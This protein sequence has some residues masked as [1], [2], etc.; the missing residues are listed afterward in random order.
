MNDCGY[1]QD[2]AGATK[3]DRFMA[4]SGRWRRW[5]GTTKPTIVSARPC[6][7]LQNVCNSVFAGE[8]LHIF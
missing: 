3:N 7:G 8:V 6:L 5:S 4:V 1:K 2:Y